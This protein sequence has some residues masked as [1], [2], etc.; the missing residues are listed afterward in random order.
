MV[1]F[2]LKPPQG[3]AYRA[4]TPPEEKWTSQG[5]ASNDRRLRTLIRIAGRGSNR[6]RRWLRD[7]SALPPAC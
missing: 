4:L 6:R 3:L 7:N 2:L 1:G 5:T